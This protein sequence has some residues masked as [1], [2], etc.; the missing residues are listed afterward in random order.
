MSQPAPERPPPAY[1]VH[2]GLLVAAIVLA[3]LAFATLVVPEI[4]DFHLVRSAIQAVK[5]AWA[6]FL[7]RLM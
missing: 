3:A 7:G 4:L 2:R 5:D 1:L 6:E